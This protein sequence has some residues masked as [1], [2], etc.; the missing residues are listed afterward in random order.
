MQKYTSAKCV[1]K[2][3]RRAPSLRVRTFYPMGQMSCNLVGKWAL[4]YGCGGTKFRSNWLT[5][6]KVVL[7][8]S[9][10][11]LSLTEKSD[12]VQMS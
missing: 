1:Q 7:F 10:G 6:K 5:Y 11:H 8:A 2:A 4:Y 9:F 12:F 3:V